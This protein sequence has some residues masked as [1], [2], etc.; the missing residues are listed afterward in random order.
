[1]HFSL[2]SFIYAVHECLQHGNLT[3]EMRNWP[4]VGELWSNW[5][6]KVVVG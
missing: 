4:T 2:L 3:E 6:H 1:L 5:N